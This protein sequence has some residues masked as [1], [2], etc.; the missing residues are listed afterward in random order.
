MKNL[1]QKAIFIVVKNK[2]QLKFLNNFGFYSEFIFI[3]S[4][5]KSQKIVLVKMN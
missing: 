5:N 3:F 4:N 2:N 1:L